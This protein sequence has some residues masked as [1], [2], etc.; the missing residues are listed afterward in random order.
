MPDQPIDA[1]FETTTAGRTAVRLAL[2]HEFCH[3]LDGFLQAC[4]G[5]PSSAQL[6]TI[7]DKLDE[8]LAV[9]PPVAPIWVEPLDGVPAWRRPRG[10]RRAHGSHAQ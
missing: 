1:E 7:R 4:N 9:P 3:W 2:P 6:Q 10:K 8:S 5:A